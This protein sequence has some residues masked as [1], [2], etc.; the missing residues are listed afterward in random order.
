[1]P[2]NDAALQDTTEQSRQAQD[3]CASAPA[4]D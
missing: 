4:K 3:E 1:V 2:Q